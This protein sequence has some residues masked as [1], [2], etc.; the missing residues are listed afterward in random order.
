MPWWWFWNRKRILTIGS[1]HLDTIAVG[2]H[3]EGDAAEPQTKAGEITHSIGGSAYNLAANLARYRPNRKYLK[4]VAVYTILPK[5]SVITELIRFKLKNAKV[6]LKYTRSYDLFGDKKVRGGGYVAIIDMSVKDQRFA[7]I[8]T[9]LSEEDIFRDEV[10]KDWIN[11][12]ISW[13]DCLATDVN[14]N[15]AVIDQIAEHART[16][17]KP[18]FVSL[19]SDEAALS[20]WL[21]GDSEKQATCVAARS[22]VIRRL[23]KHR[24]IPPQQIDALT[25][26]ADTGD[27]ATQ[28]EVNLICNT[29][30]AR[31]VLYAAHPHS[32]GG[33]AFLAAKENDP[34]AYFI[35][36]ESTKAAKG[37]MAGIVDAALCGFISTYV[38]ATRRNPDGFERL[39]L[40]NPNF[41]ARLKHAITHFVRDSAHSE[42]ATSGSVISFEENTAETGNIAT[43]HRHISIFLDKFPAIRGAVTAVVSIAV[44]TAL[45]HQNWPY[46]RYWIDYVRSTV[47]G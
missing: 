33:F 25:R 46:I 14:L 21:E 8:D 40:R 34:K 24:N 2:Q 19:G 32:F 5:H 38:G 29:L 42:G 15:C 28:I 37:S 41:Q 27:G 7:I 11:D 36:V 10:E 44:V 12:A 20:N 26:F 4:D 9:A 13:A 3:L 39:D 45:V 18:L 17:E 31:Y 35:P 43:L 30:R 16:H 22:Q 23:L 6:N 47:T 1:V